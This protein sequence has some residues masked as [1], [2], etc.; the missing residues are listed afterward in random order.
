MT[1]PQR[2][3]KRV[4]YA[5]GCGFR[6]IASRSGEYDWHDPSG[7]IRRGRSYRENDVW[8]KCLFAAI[9]E[10]RITWDEPA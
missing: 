10:A 5:R 6:V 4:E 7:K 3:V 2:L 9:H 1:K 8:Q